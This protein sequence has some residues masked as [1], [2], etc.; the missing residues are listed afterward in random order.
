MS[1]NLTKP[2]LPCTLGPS[3][4][5]V[6]IPTESVDEVEAV[7]EVVDLGVE[8]VVDLLDGSLT[9]ITCPRLR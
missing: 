3:D 4:I 9:L 2:I 5:S 1:E 7:V 8:A 6:N